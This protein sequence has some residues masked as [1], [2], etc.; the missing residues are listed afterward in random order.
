M[1][2]L[3]IMRDGEVDPELNPPEPTIVD[4]TVERVR[5]TFSR[6]TGNVALQARMATFDAVHGTNYRQIRNELVEQKRR[7]DFERSIGLVALDRK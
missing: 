6:L 4:R 3:V 7:E 5:A 1:E 2:N